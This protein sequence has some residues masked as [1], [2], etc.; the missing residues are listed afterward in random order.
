MFRFLGGCISRIL[1]LLLLLIVLA[2]GWF[3]RDELRSVWH[4]LH[5]P[6]PAAVSPEVAAAA[7]ARLEEAFKRHGPERIALTQT[8]LKSLLLYRWKTFL[9]DYVV[10]PDIQMNAGRI[11]LQASVPTD[12]FRGLREL[13]D[14]LSFLPDTAELAA[15]G[16][17]I[18]LARGRVALEVSEITAARIPVPQRLV[19]VILDNL[20]RRDEPGLAPNAVGLALP[21]GAT[22][23]FVSGDSLVFLHGMP[24]GKGGE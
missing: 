5:H 1:G 12:R 7:A 21:K 15:T 6:A 17:F 9:P 22:A 23:V 14:V 19:P 8:E 11:R 18:P 16:Q 10:R 13:Q 24:S 20:G 2:L 4:S 3:Y